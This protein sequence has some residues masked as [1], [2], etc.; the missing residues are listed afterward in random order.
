MEPALAALSLVVLGWAVVSHRLAQWNITGPLVFTVAGFVLGNA[1]WGPVAVDVEAPSVHV[2][3]EVTL[4]LLLFS[5]ASRVDI[6]TLRRDIGLPARLLG[7]GLP[8][9]VILGSVGA[10]LL[11]GDLTWA[12]AVFVGAA[13]APTDA[14]LSAQVINDER[15]PMRVR[16]ALNVES[17]L[18]DGIVTPIVVFA[19]AVAGSR[20]DASA[21][22]AG[23]S[24]AVLELAIG[25]AV[26]LALGFLSAKLIASASRRRWILRGGRRF[27]ALAT[28]V[29]SYSLAAALGGNGFIAAFVAGIAFGAAF[30]RV[31]PR[32]ARSGNCRSSSVKCWLW[33]CGSS[34]APRSCQSPSNTCRS[35]PCS[36][37]HSASRSSGC[38]LSPWAWSG[39]GWIG[40]R[41]CS[42][43]G[44][45]LVASPP[46]CSR[47]WR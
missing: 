24:R 42:S 26:G 3:A 29:G 44:S 20:L 18:N 22:D 28:A 2:L 37:P 34:S 19:L 30:P 1:A 10:A 47:S 12:L 46:W 14:A 43:A 9:S 33:E 40:G 27:A 16:R 8:L 4:A 25:I 38:S 21:E 17:G 15:V 35:P 31:S 23:G 32:S 6:A 39:P 13:L 45:D 36:M 5:D 41:S 11:F 7:V